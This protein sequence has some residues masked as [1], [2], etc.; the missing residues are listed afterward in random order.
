MYNLSV[1]HIFAAE[2]L[3]ARTLFSNPCVFKISIKPRLV[4]DGRSLN[5]H[6]VKRFT[7][8]YIDDTCILENLEFETDIFSGRFWFPVPANWSDMGTTVPNLEFPDAI[9]EIQ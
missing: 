8:P 2:I 1:S 7:L 4:Y 5:V 9:E 3:T 6:F